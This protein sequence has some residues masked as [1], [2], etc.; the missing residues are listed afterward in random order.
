MW[1]N[2]NNNK[3]ISG[4]SIDAKFFFPLNSKFDC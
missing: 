4:W 2:N 3:Q 1:D